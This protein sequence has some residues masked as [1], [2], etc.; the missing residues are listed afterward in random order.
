MRF[1]TLFF[2]VLLLA[3]CDV[4]YPSGSCPIRKD[5]SGSFFSKPYSLPIK[6]YVPRS[7]PKNEVAGVLE[8]AHIWN[9][10]GAHYGRKIFRVI[11]GQGFDGINLVRDELAPFTLPPGQFA[12]TRRTYGATSGQITYSPHLADQDLAWVMT[13]ELG[14]ALGLNH[15]CNPVGDR[16]DY[17]GCWTLKDGHAYLMSVM[18]PSAEKTIVNGQVTSWISED[19]R[20][21][22]NDVDRAY[23][24]LFAPK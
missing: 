13:H 11:W 15:S 23:C 10:F 24:L 16:K 19:P 2:L 21:G 7:T 20:L 5:Q 3:G 4:I 8:A 6:I 12:K 18:I 14:H 9:Q 17:R 1:V 22:Q